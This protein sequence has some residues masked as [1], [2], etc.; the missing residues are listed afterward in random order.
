MLIELTDSFLE[1]SGR[2][3]LGCGSQNPEDCL[4]NLST[5]LRKV[6]DDIYDFL[7]TVC[8]VIKGEDSEKLLDMKVAKL[9]RS[10]ETI[11]E[12]AYSLKLAQSE[13]LGNQH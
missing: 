9:S 12:S 6:Y 13:H 10:I 5:P 2:F 3:G 11:L 1:K 7:R 4:Q 8:H